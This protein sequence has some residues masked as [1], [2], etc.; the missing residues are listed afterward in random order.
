MAVVTLTFPSGVHA[1]PKKDPAALETC[2][3]RKLKTKSH[4]GIEYCLI[5][6]G[7]S[8]SPKAAKGNSV[9]VDYSGWLTDGKLFDS[10][11]G[12]GPIE[13][14]LGSGQVIPGWEIGVEGMHVKEKRQLSIP[15]K[16]A[17]GDAGAPGVIPPNSTL[18][19]N[20]E[21]VEVKP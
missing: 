2:K 19:F 7:D 8:K 11:T 21:L 9:R 14:K 12:R 3:Q 6:A 1:N 13:F 20:V 4:H 5:S 15:P 10:S 18:I 16:L 17:Y